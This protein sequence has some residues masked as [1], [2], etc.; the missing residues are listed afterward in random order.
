MENRSLPLIFLSLARDAGLWL[1]GAA[2]LVGAP[3]L[4]VRKWRT[5]RRFNIDCEFAPARWTLRFSDRLGA[6]P[7]TVRAAKGPRVMFFATGWGEMETLKPLIGALRTARPN[8]RVLITTKHPETIEA[9]AGVSDE[10][11]SPLPFDNVISVA[12]WLRKTRPDAVIFYERI[13]Y[14]ILLR[15]L[16][17]QR[18]PFVVLHARVNWKTPKSKFSLALKKWQLRG[19]RALLLATPEHQNGARERMPAEAQI[20]VVGSIKFPFQT[21]VLPAERADDLRAWIESGAGGA[22]LLAAGSTHETEEEFVL[23]ALERVRRQ[24]S[25]GAAPAL[26]LAPRKPARADAICALLQARGFTFSRRSQEPSA[27]P[28]DVLLLDTLG[29]LKVAHRFAVAAFVGG[30]LCGMS[31]NVAEPLIWS[32]PVSFGPDEDNFKLEHQLCLQAGVGFRVHTP[33]ELAAHWTQILDSPAHRAQLAQK[34]DDLIE[35]QRH[36][37]NRTLRALVETVDGAGRN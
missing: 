8:V 31:H 24:R 3:W 25:H 1:Y 5:M 2:T 14:G 36:A 19:T 15:A 30:T 23:D 32:I 16:W 29:E 10:V 6:Q 34:A 13:D 33:D 27:A 9:A 11:V 4:V 20:R 22:P 12:R 17:R 28:V 35:S 26:L 7:R 18:V 37:F 21:P